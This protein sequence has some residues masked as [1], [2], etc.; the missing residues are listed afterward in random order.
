MNLS[1]ISNIIP[2]SPISKKEDK[3]PTI[4]FPMNPSLFPQSLRIIQNQNKVKDFHDR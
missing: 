1:K 4:V 3:K 2:L